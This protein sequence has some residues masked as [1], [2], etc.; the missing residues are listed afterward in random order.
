M[1]SHSLVPRTEEEEACGGRERGGGK[2]PLDRASKCLFPLITSPLHYWHCWSSGERAGQVSG[3][4]SRTFLWTGEAGKTRG[5]WEA[6]G[7]SIREE[8]KARKKEKGKQEQR[9]SWRDIRKT[10][11]PPHLENR[12]GAIF[13]L[14]WLAII[15]ARGEKGKCEVGVVSGREW[16]IRKERLDRGEPC[17]KPQPRALRKGRLNS[18]GRQEWVMVFTEPDPAHAHVPRQALY[19]PPR[20]PVHSWACQV[21]RQPRHRDVGEDAT[22]GFLEGEGRGRGSA[23]GLRAPWAALCKS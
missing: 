22:G 9:G 7:R 16:V 3:L 21:A 15:C 14:S 23:W 10:S 1:T 2:W 12:P 6:E 19:S 8:K 18:A 20:T 13:R 17:T 11:R 5:A 4:A